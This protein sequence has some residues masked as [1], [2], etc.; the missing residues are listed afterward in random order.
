ML[1]ITYRH[2]LPLEPRIDPALDG[3]IVEVF[4][5]QGL[6]IEFI[7]VQGKGT[8][9]FEGYDSIMALAVKGG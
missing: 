4:L 8:V 2:E 9:E 5:P 3:N 6:V 7:I 1:P